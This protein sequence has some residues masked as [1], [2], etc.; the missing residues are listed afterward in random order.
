V[1]I[2]PQLHRRV[3]TSAPPCVFA[4]CAV[5]H[6]VCPPLAVIAVKLSERVVVGS[7][8]NSDIPKCQKIT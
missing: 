1:E 7:I 2:R 6:C 3:R 5:I 4:Q 8:V